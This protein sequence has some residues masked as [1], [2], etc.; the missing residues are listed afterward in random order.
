MS[1]PRCADAGAAD[2]VAAPPVASAAPAAEI[3]SPARSKVQGKRL[4]LGRAWEGMGTCLGS[5]RVEALCER[6]QSGNRLTA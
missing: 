6:E 4:G 2:A 1:L 3:T 5:K